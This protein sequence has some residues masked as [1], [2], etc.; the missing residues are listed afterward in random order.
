[1]ETLNIGFYQDLMERRQ[2]SLSQISFLNE[3]RRQ[4]LHLD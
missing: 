1:V 3:L 2:N 4:M